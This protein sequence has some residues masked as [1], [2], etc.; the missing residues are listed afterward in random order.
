MPQANLKEQFAPQFLGVNLR[1]DRARIED[2]EMASAINADFHTLPGGIQSRNGRQKQFTTALT[3]GIVRYLY[4]NRTNARRYQ[5]VGR[6]LYRNQISIFSSL[7]TNLIT[8]AFQA[9]P[10]NELTTFTYFA[11][12]AF[13]RKDDGT[14]L[15][16]WGISPPGTA[17]TAAAGAGGLTGSYQCRYTWA[18]LVA[19]V[20]VSES[21]PSPASAA[22]ALSGGG[23]S[24]TNLNPSPDPQV[25]HIV[26]YRTLAGG[27]VFYRETTISNTTSTSVLAVA[28]VTMA[29]NIPLE[30]DNSIPPLASWATHWK[31]TAWLCR[32]TANPHYLRFSR[33]FRPDTFPADNFLELGNPDDPLMCAYPGGEAMAAFSRLTKYR[34]VGNQESGFAFAEAVSHRGTPSPFG[35]TYYSGGLVFVARDGI[36]VTDLSGP[37]FQLAEDILPLFFAQPVNG[38]NPINWDAANT[39]RLAY[40][41]DRVY[42]AYPSGGNVLPDTVAVLSM[43]TKKWYFYQYPTAITSFLIE[44]DQDRLTAGD[45]VGFVYTIE[46]GYGDDTTTVPLTVETKDYMGEDSA[47]RRKIFHFFRVDADVPVGET[48]TATF[49]VDGVTQRTVTIIGARTKTLAA[50]PESS[51]GFQWRVKLAYTGSQQVKVYGVDAVWIALEAA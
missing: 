8:T 23:L 16:L 47:I 41:K 31:E 11:D 39:I 14:T 18:K 51:V 49:F 3:G 28:D 34:V 36:F 26:L 13:M 2:T 42:F 6:N 50:L 29:A 7:S 30:T 5:I 45:S 48:L 4:R 38:F 19:G 20:I 24:M 10:L 1:N 33:R 44:E 37:D 15:G 22:V 43:K 9:R 12:D 21:S 40:F 17:P 46:R 32:E 25:T 27:S 35:V